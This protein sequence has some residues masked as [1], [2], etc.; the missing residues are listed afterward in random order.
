MVEMNFLS[1][2]DGVS[3]ARTRVRASAAALVA[4]ALV[5]VLALVVPSAA[6]ATP[7]AS[8]ELEPG[9]HARGY[10]TEKRLR[11]ADPRPFTPATEGGTAQGGGR[12]GSGEPSYTPPSAPTTGS[13]TT[14]S[15]RRSTQAGSVDFEVLD[16]D[17]APN[18]AHGKVFARDAGG[19]FSCSATVIT[20]QTRSILVTAGHC[21]KESYGWVRR[22][23][24][25]PAYHDGQTPFGVWRASELWVPRQWARVGNINYDFA[26]VELAPQ[27]GIAVQDAV[28]G[29]GLAANLSPNQYYQAFGYPFNFFQTE[30][31]MACAGQ[32]IGSERTGWRG[33]RPVGFRC[34][35]GQGSSGGGWIVQG[36]YVNSLMSHGPPGKAFGPYFGNAVVN[37]VARADRP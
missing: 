13:V 34:G 5:C 11:E 14:G 23:V 7:A 20:S 27:N 37:L 26:V 28:G 33:P 31:L 21:V 22:F 35:M 3:Q 16:W 19:S 9:H 10:W 32:Y 4:A 29:Y 36:G 12:S 6:M 1:F 17:T 25:V 2:Q 24:F 15:G 18:I 8:H 30:R